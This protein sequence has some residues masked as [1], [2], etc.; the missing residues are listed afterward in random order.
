M[1]DIQNKAVGLALGLAVSVLL[2][3]AQVPLS[4]RPAA[5]VVQAIEG[6]VPGG[7]IL[8]FRYLGGSTVV[9]LKGTERAPGAAAKL[10]VESRRGFLE[11]TLKR[12]DIKGLEPAEKFGRDFL[13]Y[14]LWA[15]SADG[16]VMNLGE[17]TFERGVPRSLNVTTPTRL[18]G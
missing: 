16:A 2:A 1:P 4:V 18:F 13:T 3:T 8:S 9:E 15:V 10:K 17:I 6:A 12:G 11:I 5:A 7:Q 14:V